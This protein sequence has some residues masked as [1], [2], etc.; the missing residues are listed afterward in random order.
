MASKKQE[1]DECDVCDEPFNKS[2]RV[3]I[4]CRVCETSCCKVCVRNYICNSIKDAHCM[5]CKAHWD[6]GCLVDNLNKSFVDFIYSKSFL[7]FFFL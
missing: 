7:F 3:E 6:R 2:T 1:F 5:S 4:A